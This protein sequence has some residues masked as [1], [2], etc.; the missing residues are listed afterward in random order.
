[1]TGSAD[2]VWVATGDQITTAEKL[3]KGFDLGQPHK[4]L[5]GH[6]ATVSS[7]K[8]APLLREVS[9][10]LAIVWRRGSARL[11]SEGRPCF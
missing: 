9:Q 1:M 4:L 2:K 7:T 6:S 8:R 11:V 5:Y 3:V 10:G